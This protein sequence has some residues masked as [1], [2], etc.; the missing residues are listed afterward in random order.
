MRAPGLSAIYGF[1]FLFI[2]FGVRRFRFDA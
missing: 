1:A 2:A